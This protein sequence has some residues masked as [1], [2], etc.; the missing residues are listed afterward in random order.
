M[1]SGDALAHRLDT[2]A[3][4]ATLALAERARAMKAR[5]E[6]VVSLTA[7]E[8][9]FAAAPHV[10]DAVRRC[11]VEGAY[12]YTAAAG[13]PELR[14]AIARRIEAQ[15]GLRYAPDELVVS[16]GAKQ[17]LMNAL[18]A[19]LD[20]GDEVV[21]FAPFWLSYRDMSALAGGVPVVVEARAEDGFQPSPD[22][23]ARALT[24]RTRVVILNSPSNPAGA[25]YDA[26]TLRA[27]ADVLARHPD[28][29]VVLDEI[30]RRIH[31]AGGAAPSLLGVAPELAPRTVVIDGASKTYAMTGFR[32]G[33]A[34]GPAWLVEGMA[35]VQAQTTSSPVSPSQ[36]AAIAALEGDQG[37]VDDMVR[38]Y[39]ARA[40]V[41]VARLRAIPGLTLVPPRGAFYAFPGVDA[42]LGR[43]SP[44]TGAVMRDGGDVVEYLLAEHGLV[45]VPGGPFGAPRH[46]RMSFATD[47]ATIERGI[48]RLAAG[49]GALV[50]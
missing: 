1:S 7:G 27:L 36:H 3:D 50:A 19:L 21:M 26:A 18:Q 5:G 49:L 45:L 31:F 39:A 37:W 23:L 13:M 6:D 10:L 24:P 29:I 12:R 14:R 30:Y 16:T 32:I 20:P 34:A 40:E 35:R 8:P 22:A 48:A 9:D 17:A 41:V 28:V 43:R 44:K 4:S 2:V 38:T 25:T 46:V 42:Y 15:D 11:L 47:L 33:W